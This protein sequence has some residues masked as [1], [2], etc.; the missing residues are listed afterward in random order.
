MKDLD[1]ELIKS[2]CN[3]YQNERLS[4]NKISKKLGISSLRIKTALLKSNVKLDP[5]HLNPIYK[6]SI[7]SEIKHLYLDKMMGCKRIGKELGISEKRI[8][9]FLKDEG[10]LQHSRNKKHK[11]NSYFFSE[12]DCEE[13]AYWLGVLYADG[14]VSSSTPEIKF[15][16]TDK[17]WVEMFLNSIGS[18]DVPHREFHKKFQKEIWK[19]RIT[20]KKLHND[21]ISVGCVPAKSLII[22]FPELNKDLIRHFIRGYFDGD[23]FVTISNNSTKKENCYTLK[24]GFCSGSEIFVKQLVDKI[25]TKNKIVKKRNKPGQLYEIKLSVNDSYKL[26]KYIYTNASVFLQR[27]KDKFDYYIKQRRSE[28]IIENLEID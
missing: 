20:D 2:I 18:T 4:L 25:P 26:Y 16:S 13:K 1:L 19:A 28:T 27:K 12:I 21:L 8:A 17:E 15:T 24:S 11:C 22:E 9:K 14:N 10:L 7:K 3:L 23:G 6:D 5:D